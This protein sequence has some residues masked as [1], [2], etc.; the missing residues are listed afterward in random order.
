VVN[1]QLSI[2]NGNGRFLLVFSVMKW[3]IIW[4]YGLNSLWCGETAGIIVNG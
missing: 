2:V 1:C 4:E 3:Q